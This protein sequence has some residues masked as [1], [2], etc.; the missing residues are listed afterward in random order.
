MYMKIY[1][2]LYVTIWVCSFLI[3]IVKQIVQPKLLDSN[4]RDCHKV[5]ECKMNICASRPVANKSV[6]NSV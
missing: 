6:S 3:L 1:Y 4:G 2:Y 5:K